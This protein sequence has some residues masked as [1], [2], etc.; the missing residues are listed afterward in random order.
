MLISSC[1]H[2]QNASISS[3]CCMTNHVEEIKEKLGH[4]IQEEISRRTKKKSYKWRTCYECHEYGH[5]AKD[6]P[7]LDSDVPSSSNGAS[8]SPTTHICLMAKSVKVTSSPSILDDNIEE[9]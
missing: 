3:S 7:N 8:S 1:D 4:I 2:D 9:S 6:C 5:L